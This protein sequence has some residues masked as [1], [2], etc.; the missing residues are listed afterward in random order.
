MTL[1]YLWDTGTSDADPGAGKLRGNNATTASI[2]TLYIDL[3]DYAGTTQTGNLDTFD[4][5]TNTVKGNIRVVN[6][7]DATKWMT[8]SLTSR[9]TATGYRKLG[10]TYISQ[11]G[12]SPF[13]NGDEVLLCF[14]RAGDAGA[15]SWSIVTDT[16][17]ATVTFA[18]NTSRLHR[19]VLGG[20]RTL[21]LSGDAD[22][23]VFYVS[24]VQDGTGSRTVTWWS[25]ILWPGGT[26]PTLTTAINKADDFVFIR[27][28]SG[29]YHGFVLG[30][31]L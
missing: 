27:I 12:A 9:T 18:I 4:A 16:D 10:V 1:D 2:T 23:N 8:F 15:T 26:T 24:L 7:N 25:G 11:S 29:V 31:N 17:G 3:V 30:Q 22:G 19:V 6:K 5:S 14:E 20:N 13:A 21:A 28:S